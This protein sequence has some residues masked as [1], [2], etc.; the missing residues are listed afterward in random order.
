MYIPQSIYKTVKNKLE[1]DS[2]Q[3]FLSCKEINNL[4]SE[5]LD[6]Y[7]YQLSEKKQYSNA[8]I[9]AI[10]YAL[11][12]ALKSFSLAIK[13]NV[14]F[15]A[16]FLMGLQSLFASI[17]NAIVSI[18]IL[19][20]RGLYHP[21]STILRNIYELCFT[22]LNILIDE[23]KRYEY[24]SN[25]ELIMKRGKW[26]KHFSFKSLNDTIKEYETSIADGKL[27]FM[28]DLRNRAYAWYSSSA[29]N[30][31]AH[32]VCGS[33]IAEQQNEEGSFLSLN[34]GGIPN[35]RIILSRL[36]DLDDLLF[37]TTKMLLKLLAFQNGRIDPKDIVKEE[38]MEMWLQSQVLNCLAEEMYLIAK[39][40]YEMNS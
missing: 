8:E 7:E 5:F 17:F 33:F 27:G 19:L 34:V 22:L 32:L 6:L 39:M 10:L 2:E 16:A 1:F 20:K 25:K 3:L 23:E 37:Y 21:A 29:H 13:D 15:P 26:R 38:S 35:E 36:I 31:Y 30:G 12:F 14:A 9:I 4:V 24:T 40:D 18:C 28:S 11:T